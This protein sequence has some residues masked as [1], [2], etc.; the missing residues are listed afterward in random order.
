MVTFML[1]ANFVVIIGDVSNQA[2]KQCSET[3]GGEAETVAYAAHCQQEVELDRPIAGHTNI[4]P[5]ALNSTK[6]EVI[7]HCVI[8]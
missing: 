2:F 3:I 8:L 6:I 7:R 5:Q 1:L 4:C